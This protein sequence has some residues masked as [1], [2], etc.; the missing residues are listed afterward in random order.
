MCIVTSLLQIKA[1]IACGQLKSAYLLAVKF[2]RLDDIECILQEAEK[3]GQT[4][5]KKICLKRLGRL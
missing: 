5:I 4:A 1:F 2:E 3:L